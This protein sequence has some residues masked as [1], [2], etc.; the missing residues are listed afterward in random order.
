MQPTSFERPMLGSDLISTLP[1]FMDC[2]LFGRQAVQLGHLFGLREFETR[3]GLK[4]G[5]EMAW[6]PFRRLLGHP[7]EGNLSTERTMWSQ[8]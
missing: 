5:P 2:I 4:G 1:E 7:K 6:L 3:F 8:D